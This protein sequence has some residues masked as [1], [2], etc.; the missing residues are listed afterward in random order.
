MQHALAGRLSKV[1]ACTCK[2]AAR[3]CLPAQ[4]LSV[5]STRFARRGS[6]LAL[7]PQ[8]RRPALQRAARLH[9]LNKVCSIGSGRVCPAMVPSLAA[10][11]DLGVWLLLT[12]TPALRRLTL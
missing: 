8:R 7:Q 3:S 2:H 12:R 9:A 1:Q 10:E 5:Q 11:L 4:R 6:V